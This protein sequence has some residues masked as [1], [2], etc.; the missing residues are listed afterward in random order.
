MQTTAIYQDIGRS[1]KGEDGYLGNPIR[2]QPGES[3]GGARFKNLRITS[4]RD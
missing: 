3:R 4:I 2:L 1:G